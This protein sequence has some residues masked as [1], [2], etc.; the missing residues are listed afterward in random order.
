MHHE[1]TKCLSLRLNDILKRLTK[2]DSPMKRTILSFM[3]LCALCGWSWPAA[4][5]KLFH[6]LDEIYQDT[7]Y[8]KAR[9]RVEEQLRRRAEQPRQAMRPDT[10]PV[11]EVFEAWNTWWKKGRQS[12][13]GLMLT[14]RLETTF[15]VDTTEPGSAFKHTFMQAT[16]TAMLRYAAAPSLPLSTWA[17][18]TTSGAEQ[19]LWT[20]PQPYYA[21]GVD[22]TAL[23]RQLMQ[24]YGTDNLWRIPATWFSGQIC[25]H[26][27]YWDYCGTRVCLQVQ[28]ADV[29]H[30]RITRKARWHE[31]K[32]ILAWYQYYN[33]FQQYFD[34]FRHAF[35]YYHPLEHFYGEAELM[36]LADMIRLQLG[37]KW[38][39]V[40]DILSDAHAG[41]FY[42]LLE[43]KNDG[44][45]RLHMLKRFYESPRVSYAEYYEAIKL[46]RQALA[47][48]PP[49]LLGHFMTTDGRVFPYRIITGAAISSYLTDNKYENRWVM[50]DCLFYQ[51]KNRVSY[52]LTWPNPIWYCN[53]KTEPE[54]VKL[55]E[56]DPTYYIPINW[57]TLW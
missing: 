39:Q 19:L 52:A 17:L 33:G 25:M 8:V 2:T 49:H 44:H 45:L 15:L 57:E 41:E 3:L 7:N 38:P 6:S 10:V 26:L 21:T 40:F 51:N 27:N 35:E 28:R 30:G 54:K 1:R 22:T 48:L 56:K 12:L 53:P 43:E 20:G 18:D 31:Q 14:E 29:N 37:E 36:V 16:P 9:Q 23:R 46:L 42:F 11:G 32:G 34:K 55:W 47:A 4:A 13:Q 50:K 24:R 5:Q